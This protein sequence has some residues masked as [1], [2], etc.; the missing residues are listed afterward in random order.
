[1]RRL[2]LFSILFVA[3]RYEVRVDDP[4]DAPAPDAG[5]DAGEADAPPLTDA[6]DAPL[7]ACL[8]GVPLLTLADSA[9][10]GSIT[11][12]A[13]GDRFALLLPPSTTGASARLVHVDREGAM[14]SSRD[15]TLLDGTGAPTD[16]IAVHRRADGPGFVLLGPTALQLL[17]AAGADDGAAIALPDAPDPEHLRA[18]G[19]LDGA[20]FVYA[21]AGAGRPL[22]DVRV[23]A[24]ERTASLSAASAD[25]AARVCVGGGV[26]TIAELAPSTVAREHDVTL[27]A[28][29]LSTSW[30]DGMP[31]AHRL[32]GA[33]TDTER[34][35]LVS[36]GSEFRSAVGAYRVDAA[37]ATLI[38][39]AMT[40]IGP[41][42]VVQHGDLVS[43]RAGDG[44]VRAYD[45][46]RARFF[47]LGSTTG[48][49]ALI[50]RDGEGFVWVTLDGTTL[51]FRCAEP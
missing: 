28:P 5:R 16:A 42:D 35:W 34:R 47:E 6:P 45:F 11:L 10:A 2:A 22:V 39:S 23:T 30:P 49:V 27:G 4:L 32:F 44:A 33:F 50:E 38:G 31:I 13:S 8:G 46:S 29:T 9:A 26:V 1:M 36:D 3:C 24:T 25:L 17:D 43:T 18:A 21:A 37:G 51:T 48:P 15:V 40:V 41:V 7:R 12:A 19:W 20:H 14:L